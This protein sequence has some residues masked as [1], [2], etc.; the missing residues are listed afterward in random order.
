MREPAARWWPLELFLDAA[1]G[2]LARPAR[3]LMT[4]SAILLGLGAIVITS[5]L[6]GAAA[7]NVVATFDSYAATAVTLRARGERI[8]AVPPEAIDRLRALPGVTAVGVFC[9]V[10]GPPPTTAARGVSAGQTAPVVGVSAGGM[11]ALS[12]RLS[13]RDV[14][15]VGAMNHHKVA[16]IG[17]ATLEEFQVAPPGAGS[18]V[19]I[20]GL[21]FAVGGVVEDVKR[22]P[23]AVAE[24][25][26]PL[27]VAR[28]LW[29]APCTTWEVIIE[30][31]RAATAGVGAVAAAGATPQD[32]EAWT[33][34][35]PP[36]PDE[37]ARQVSTDLSTLYLTLAAM[38]FAIGVL[39][40]ANTMSI[41]VLERTGEIGLRRAL[42][43]TRRDVQALFGIEATLLGAL[44]G[45]LGASFGSLVVIG[46]CLVRDWPVVLSAPLL[47]A[48]TPI[49]ALIGLLGG[50]IPAARAGRLAPATALR[51]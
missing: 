41:S 50:M 51:G 46:V 45:L 34:I 23:S 17:G 18:A 26:V 36:S 31:D 27:D 9:T 4:M 14:T 2:L 20:D 32:P 49:G 40:I 35:V 3:A 21:G 10:A 22:R 24:V 6:A 8:D 33:V 25:F 38:S 42:G 37:L 44:G 43:F 39:S 5:G 7:A 15:A 19:V 16:V 12:P 48:C 47:L 28:H 1:T 30:T 11:A 13:G 29:P